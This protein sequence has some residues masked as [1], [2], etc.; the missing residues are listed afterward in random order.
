M[1]TTDSP[2]LGRLAHLN[3]QLAV[4]AARVDALVAAQLDQVERLFRAAT[5]HDWDA[6][7]RLSRELAQRTDGREQAAIS[8]TARKVCEAL[9]RDPSGG[10]A[11]APLAKLLDACRSAKKQA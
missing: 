5:A 6:V 11:A 9:G 10:K 1:D 7:G 4:Q 2:S 8:R 3:A